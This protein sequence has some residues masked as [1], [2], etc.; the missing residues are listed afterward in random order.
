MG[1]HAPLFIDKKGEKRKVTNY[2][3]ERRDKNRKYNLMVLNVPRTSLDGSTL[4][5]SA[6]RVHPNIPLCPPPLENPGFTPEQ[7]SILDGSGQFKQL[8]RGGMVPS[9]MPISGVFLSPSHI[10]L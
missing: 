8:E 1:V 3:R 4:A 5:V 9:V 6:L 10:E 7:V 2:K